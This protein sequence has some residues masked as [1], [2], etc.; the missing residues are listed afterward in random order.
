MTAA[1]PAMS[2]FYFYPEGAMTS[3]QQTQS[4]ASIQMFFVPEQMSF[5]RVDVPI[6]VSLAS[7]ATANTGNIVINGGRLKYIGTGAQSTA[8]GLNIGSGGAILVCV[9]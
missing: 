8:L 3:S 5:T 1:P 2:S 6:L 7:S 9:S 4:S